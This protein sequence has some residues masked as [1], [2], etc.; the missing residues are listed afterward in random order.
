VVW[1]LL[2]P[3]AA[4][5]RVLAGRAREQLP[6]LLL[7]AG[8]AGLALVPFMLTYLPVLPTESY[9]SFADVL[10]GLPDRVPQPMGTVNLML[11]WAGLAVA[12]TV[13]GDA[14]TPFAVPRA[15]A[16]RR[17]A[18]VTLVMGVT[19][20]VGW[21][22]LFESGGWTLWYWVFTCLPGASVLRALYRFHHVPAGVVAVGTVALS[23]AFRRVDRLDRWRLAATALIAVVAANANEQVCPTYVFSKS[24]QLTMLHAVPRPPR[25]C[26]A[27]YVWGGPRDDGR[28]T[29]VDAM[30]IAQATSLPTL[31]GYSGRG[32]EGWLLNWPP[33]RT[34]YERQVDVWAHRHGLEQGLCRLDLTTKAWTPRPVRRYGRSRGAGRT[35]AGR[36]PP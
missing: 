2:D 18:A 24:A 17:R 32:P 7:L 13:N 23:A 29:Q 14:A 31:N 36:I 22:L 5:L 26:R 15:R 33:D 4:S 12:M 8:V 6:L 34:P 10:A 20:L 11:F 16:R 9:V 19:V 35:R 27:F 30:M 25:Q 21:G 3:H 1:S 28:V